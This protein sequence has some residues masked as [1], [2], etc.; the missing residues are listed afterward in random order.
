MRRHLRGRA[1]A[2]FACAAV[3]AA[4]NSAEFTFGGPLELDVTSNSPISVSDSLRVEYDVSGRTLLGMEIQWGDQTRD[5]LFFSAAQSA[6]GFRYHTYD[7]AGTYTL[8][9]AVTD[10]IEGVVTEELTIVVNP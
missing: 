6:G 5:S 9:A 7:S 1:W 2:I 10:Q 3:G 4:C 8:T